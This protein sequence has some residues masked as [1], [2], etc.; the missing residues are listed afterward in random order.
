MA[1]TG[2][3]V[4]RLPRGRMPADPM[5]HSDPARG[6]LALRDLLCRGTLCLAGEGGRLDE[7]ALNQALKRRS[8]GA[9]RKALSEEAARRK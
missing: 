2:P 3:Q 4:R 1:C 5:A 6:N 9:F 7:R 8:R